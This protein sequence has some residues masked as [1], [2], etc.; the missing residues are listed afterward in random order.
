M[1]ALKA[2]AGVPLL[3]LLTVR[4]GLFVWNSSLFVSKSLQKPAPNCP[5]DVVT[6]TRALVDIDSPTGLEQEVFAY[7]SAWAKCQ[8]YS[9]ITQPISPLAS[10]QPPRSN[11]LVLHPDVNESQI[12]VVLS[13]HLDTV[14]IANNQNTNTD[15]D[16]KIRGRGSVDA[17]GQAAAMLVAVVARLR[18]P[19]VAV[20]LVCGE[21]SDHAGMLQAHELGFGSIALVNGEPTESKI[22]TNQKGA[23]RM[24]ITVA[25]KAAHSGYPHLGDSAIHKMIDLLQQLRRETCTQG[26]TMNVGIIEGGIAPNVVADRASATVFWRVPRNASATISIAEQIGKSYDGVTMETLRWNDGIDFYVPNLAKKVGTTAVAYNTDIPFFKGR[27]VRT[28]LFGGG[29]IF[30]A[31]TEDEYIDRVELEQLPLLYE[32]IVQ[33]LVT[34]MEDNYNHDEGELIHNSRTM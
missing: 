30:Q 1:L 29:S 6:L 17:K 15:D 5:T 9:T 21:E 10:G 7:A 23:I 11:L 19:H 14:V 26:V 32:E 18:H 16:S 24:A 33:Q 13:T 28:V 22:A 3:L 34:E 4:F 20:L 12:V 27:T 31:H 8:N 2:A 25:G